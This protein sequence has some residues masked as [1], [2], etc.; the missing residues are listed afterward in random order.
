[1]EEDGTRNE[2]AWPGFFRSL[3]KFSYQ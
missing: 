1:S 2:N 3:E